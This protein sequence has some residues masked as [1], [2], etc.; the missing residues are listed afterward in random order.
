MEEWAWRTATRV[1]FIKTRPYIP[2]E[3]LSA[4]RVEE[5]QLPPELGDWIARD[6]NDATA[7]W[8]IKSKDFERNYHFAPR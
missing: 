4:V 3:N 8:L 7:Q 6:P 5:K 1:T 2:G